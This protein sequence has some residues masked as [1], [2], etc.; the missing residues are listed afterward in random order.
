M[1]TLQVE[2]RA[3]ISTDGKELCEAGGIIAAQFP[4]TADIHTNQDT[5]MVKIEPEVL[6]YLDCS[7]EFGHR[8][9]V[10]I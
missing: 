2:G 10:D 5:V 1:Q 4:I 3:T 9:K 6:Y 7:V 8:E